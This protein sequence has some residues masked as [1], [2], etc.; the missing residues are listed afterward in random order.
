MDG[1]VEEQKERSRIKDVINK[2]FRQEKKRQH[3]ARKR[4]R[5]SQVLPETTRDERMSSTVGIP[6]CTSHLDPVSPEN[7][8]LETVSKLDNHVSTAGDRITK[9]HAEASPPP[10]AG[11]GGNKYQEARLLMHYLDQ[12]FP[13][14]FPYHD[15][16]SRLG[17]RGWLFL[18]LVKRGPLYHAV[19]SLSSLHQ[20]AILDAKEDILQ[21]QKALSHHSRALREL[22]DIM[23][24]KGDKLRDDHG[25]LADF[26]ACS[27]ILISFEV[28]NRKFMTS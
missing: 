14:Q 13:W 6:P 24:E 19:L 4:D 7:E 17:N 18:L 16:Q 1:G 12:V 21:K 27:F 25:Q 10:I 2:N 11:Y 9:L 26:L 8:S 20:S 28:R 5:E 3:L 15:C 22:C 23:S